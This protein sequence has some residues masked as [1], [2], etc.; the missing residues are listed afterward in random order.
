MKLKNY[1]AMIAALAKKYPD[2]TV[3]CASDDEGNAFQ[4]VNYHPTP[5]TFLEGTFQNS[6]GSGLKINA[7][8]VN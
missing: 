6:N 3:V 1:A 8:C 7:V 4:T 5:G 2:A